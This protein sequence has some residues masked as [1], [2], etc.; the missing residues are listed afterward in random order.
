MPDPMIPSFGD[1]SLNDP[2]QP[3]QPAPPP[4][5][6]PVLN[7]PVKI[8][9][10]ASP[11]TPYPPSQQAPLPQQI[12]VTKAPIK[13]AGAVSPPTTYP[14][15]RPVDQPA[16]QPSFSSVPPRTISSPPAAPH[17]VDD[18]ELEI[19]NQRETATRTSDPNIALPW[20]EKVY[21]WV[22]ISLEDF[23]RDQEVAA[24]DA[25]VAPRASTPP[26]EKGLRD[27]CVRVVER[28]AK[29]GHPKAVYMRGIWFEYGDF[30]YPNDRTEA[31]HAYQ[32]A[33]KQ[34]FA[35][36]EYRLGKMYEDVGDIKRGIYHYERGV[37]Q[38][39]SAAL[40]VP[41]PQILYTDFAENGNDETLGPE[42]VS[43]EYS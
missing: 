42:R 5:Q 39:D 38:G 35:R 43:G 28:F 22:S 37:S 11:P 32:A 15:S 14:P 17:I 7:A 34:G 36:G 9:G 33:V 23:Y 6:I 27:D 8:V 4:P 10:A 16:M 26:F 40:Y 31:Y 1:L 20:A 41:H 12:P 3:S 21:M 24:S 13:I 30:K 2:Y 18:W 29:Q 25:G 19:T